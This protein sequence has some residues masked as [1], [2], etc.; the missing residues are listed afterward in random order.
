[1]VANLRYVIFGSARE[2]LEL[3]ATIDIPADIITRKVRHY[4]LFRPGTL[5][6][7]RERLR[8]EHGVPPE[9]SGRCRKISPGQTVNIRIRP[10]V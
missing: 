4:L 10:V 2:D 3:Q 8:K 9:T 1:M 6:A 7:M 5:F